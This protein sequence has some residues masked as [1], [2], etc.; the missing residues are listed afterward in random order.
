MTTLMNRMGL[1]Q[2]IQRKD[3]LVKKWTQEAAR[4]TG[5]DPVSRAMRKYYLGMAR[6]EHEKKTKFE[7]ELRAQVQIGQVLAQ[8]GR[9]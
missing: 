8:I 1:A 7:A 5:E 9:K 6:S 3:E 2:K 4:Y